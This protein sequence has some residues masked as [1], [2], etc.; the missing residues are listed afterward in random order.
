VSVLE[1]HHVASSFA[2]ML[3]PNHNILENFSKEDYK[4]ARAVMIGAILSTD[5]SKHFSE[6][7][8]FKTRI[9][10]AEFD[11]KGNDKD[12]LMFQLF[13]FADIS[14]STKPWDTCLKWTDLLFIE[15]FH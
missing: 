1:N 8:K 6:L 10:S 4:R 2:A 5:M 9:A 14:N 7:A 13:H 12:L 11:P 3:E 15:F